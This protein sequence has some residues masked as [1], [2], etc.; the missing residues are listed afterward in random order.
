[1]CLR[2]P[3]LLTYRCDENVDKQALE[4]LSSIST[5]DLNP[6]CFSLEEIR[7]QDTNTTELAVALLLLFIP[8][9]KSLGGYIYYRYKKRIISLNV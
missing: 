6:V 1:M 8:N 9:L 3:S 7:I 5:S 2:D 4:Q